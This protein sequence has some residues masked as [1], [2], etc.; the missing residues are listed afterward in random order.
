[1][2]DEHRCEALG[3]SAVATTTFDW[4][5]LCAT[6]RSSAESLRDAW[7]PRPL[8][9]KKRVART[10]TLERFRMLGEYLRTLDPKSLTILTLSENGSWT[11]GVYAKLP[12]GAEIVIAD[13]SNSPENVIFGVFRNLRGGTRHAPERNRYK[14]DLVKAGLWTKARMPE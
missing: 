1:M 7:Q 8:N 13:A 10:E 6:C 5:R 4:M 12:T 11:V 9:P 2:E 14:L 3:C